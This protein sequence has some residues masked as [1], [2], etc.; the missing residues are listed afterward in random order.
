MTSIWILVQLSLQLI[1][2]KLME[3]SA[4]RKLILS[5]DHAPGPDGFNGL[6][7]KNAGAS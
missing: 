7:I 3:I 1:W 4:S 2:I 6:F 5:N